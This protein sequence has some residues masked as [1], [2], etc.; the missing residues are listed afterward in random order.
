MAMYALGKTWF[1][2]LIANM[3]VFAVM[4]VVANKGGAVMGWVPSAYQ[5][6]S[7]LL[8]AIIAGILAGEIT[9]LFI[10]FA[11]DMYHNMIL[12][13]GKPRVIKVVEKD[14]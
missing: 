13:D 7:V 8:I 11:F 12:E 14:P 9:K 6:Y 1:S 4:E 10:Q 5:H 3:I 2:Y